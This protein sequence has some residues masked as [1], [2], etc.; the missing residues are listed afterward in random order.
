MKAIGQAAL[1]VIGTLFGTY[2]GLISVTAKTGKTVAAGLSMV[3]NAASNVAVVN[4]VTGVASKVVTGFATTFSEN[5]EISSANREKLFDEL[6]KGLEDYHP[7]SKP[8][9]I[10]PSTNEGDKSPDTTDT[11][12]EQVVKSPA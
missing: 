5:S 6:D 12:T 1:T 10:V 8:L 9:P 7:E 3:D 2:N 4:G 11:K